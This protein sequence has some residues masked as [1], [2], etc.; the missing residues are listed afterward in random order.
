MLPSLGPGW[1]ISN[2]S[3]RSAASGVASASP[4]GSSIKC[5][6][7][8]TIRCNALHSAVRTANESGSI[9]MGPEATNGPTCH[10]RR[11][12][13][14]LHSRMRL[15]TPLTQNAPSTCDTRWALGV[16]LNWDCCFVHATVSATLSRARYSSPKPPSAW[17]ERDRKLAWFREDRQG[18]A[19]CFPSTGRN[20][21][22]RPRIRTLPMFSNITSHPSIEP[23]EHQ[24]C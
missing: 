11:T 12:I 17:L 24:N 13:K 19:R 21:L 16:R 1:S 7:G 5:G 22:S 4:M 14:P 20:P 23:D 8:S 9:G 3:I 6:G 2:T 18:Q 15:D 10:S